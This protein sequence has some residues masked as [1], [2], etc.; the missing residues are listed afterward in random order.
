MTNW[1]HTLAEC[2]TK[3]SPPRRGTVICQVLANL[4]VFAVAV[5]L[6]VNKI[7]LTWFRA[8]SFPSLLW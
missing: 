5:L 1:F 3:V 8:R 7:D 4:V 6:L 2:V